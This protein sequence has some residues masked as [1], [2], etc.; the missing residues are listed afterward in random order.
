MTKTRRVGFRKKRR[1]GGRKTI[2][3][4]GRKRRTRV[5]RRGK[6]RSRMKH[7]GVS[8]IKKNGDIQKINANKNWLIDLFRNH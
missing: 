4:R 5:K 1:R 3:R 7:G 2:K 8:L 6:C